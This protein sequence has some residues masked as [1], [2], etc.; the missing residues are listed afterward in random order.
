MTGT[1]FNGIKIM[2][3]VPV[4]ILSERLNLITSYYIKII[5]RLLYLDF[6]L[7]ISLTVGT[8]RLMEA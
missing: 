8:I 5:F 7:S 2:L 3:K 4:K 1:D 6:F